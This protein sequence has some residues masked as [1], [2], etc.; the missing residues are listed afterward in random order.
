MKQ[1]DSLINITSQHLLL[2][3]I[4][5]KSR[6]IRYIEAR[7]I[8][9]TILRRYGSYKLK[10]IANI[11]SKN[12]ATIIHAL[13]EFPY[14]IKA[15]P[16]LE[17]KYLSILEEWS[18]I[19]HKNPNNV[20]NKL[21]KRLK[22]LEKQNEILNLSDNFL[23]T[24]I[25]NM[26]VWANKECKYTVDDAEKIYEYK[27]WSKKRKIDT[28]LQVDCNLYCNLGCDSTISERKEVK[29]KS[30]IIYR[31]IKKIDATIGTLLLTSR[32]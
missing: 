5:S 14:M 17:V 23:K 26:E 24:K 19:V 1:V 13:K 25:D 15:N 12:H 27:T 4:F 16:H 9:Y 28:L 8:I 2:P 20:L 10:D 29:Q 22:S 7:A 31:T 30:K 32:D 21:Q 18:G 11:F 3:D 6:Q